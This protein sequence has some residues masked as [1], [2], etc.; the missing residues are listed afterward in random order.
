MVSNID[1]KTRNLANSA[2]LPT[3]I[4]QQTVSQ[5]PPQ[6]ARS[7][8]VYR[9]ATVDFDFKAAPLHDLL[10][11]IADTGKVNIVIPDGINA[12]VTV[13]LKRVPWDQ[14]RK[15]DAGLAELAGQISVAL[16]LTAR[17]VP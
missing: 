14:A 7:R 17:P 4:A 5:L 6:G 10:R 3:P 11:T 16:E 13:R 1:G 12:K 8:K 15:L 2:G 9:G